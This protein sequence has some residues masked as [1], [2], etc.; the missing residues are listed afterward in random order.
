MH[1][2][3]GLIRLIPAR[4]GNIRQIVHSERPASA[5]PRSRGEHR[6][7]VGALRAGAGS[8]PL[9]RGTFRA[10]VRCRRRGRLIPARAGNMGPR[11]APKR[12]ISAHPRSRGEHE[13]RTMSWCWCFGS[14]PLA[15]GTSEYRRNAVDSSRLI[16]ARAGN[17]RRGGLEPVRVPAHPRSRGEHEF[18]D[19][20]ALLGSGSSPLARG[21]STPTRDSSS[22]S[23]LIPARAGNIPPSSLLP[24][25]LA[26]HP[27]SRGEHLVC[28]ACH[29]SPSGSSPLARGTSL[30]SLVYQ[31]G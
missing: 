1:D 14:S 29:Y 5:H 23:R 24:A 6:W 8:S 22:T 17:M 13:G 3:R 28:N 27:R 25:P 9:A 31:T 21:T 30:E 15:R 10:L 19:V 11:Y 7:S 20:P 16:P 2:T 4:A 26:A 12:A 18:R